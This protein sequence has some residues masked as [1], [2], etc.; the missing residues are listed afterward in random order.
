MPTKSYYDPDLSV[1]LEMPMDW[2]AAANDPFPLIL[3]AP[4]EGDFRANLSFSV[5]VLE[6]PTPEHLQQLIDQTRAERR[7]S[8]AGFEPVSEERLMQDNFPAHLEVYHWTMDG[9]GVPMTQ[10]FALI[11]TAPEA[12]YSLHATCLRGLES[13]YLPVFRGIIQSLRFIQE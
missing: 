3:M 10:V 13:H 8:F 1:S 2:E 6:P 4:P 5:Q 7:Q 9:S 12:L 11:L